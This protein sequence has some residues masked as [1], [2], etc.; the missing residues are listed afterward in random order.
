MLAMS[1][2]VVLYA[3]AMAGY[4]RLLVRVSLFLN[5]GQ[6]FRDLCILAGLGLDV[7]EE[8]EG[9]SAGNLGD[10]GELVFGEVGHCE[11]KGS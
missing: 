2:S 6:V 3:V 10:L 11:L 1:S 4:S 8:L 7:D 9:A 5:L